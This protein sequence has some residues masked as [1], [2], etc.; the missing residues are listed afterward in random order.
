MNL[1]VPLGGTGGGTFGLYSLLLEE[2]R[3]RRTDG[4]EEGGDKLRGAGVLVVVEGTDDGEHTF[5][6]N[7]SVGVTD[8][9]QWSNLNDCVRMIQSKPRQHEREKETISYTLPGD[10]EQ[11]TAIQT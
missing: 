1:G 7:D 11:Y 9:I 3:P 2:F 4:Y 8:N 6:G 5:I 10:C